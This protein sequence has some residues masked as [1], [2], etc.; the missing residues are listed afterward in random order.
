MLVA[1]STLCLFAASAKAEEASDHYFWRP[2]SNDRISRPWAV[3][4]PGS[5]GL[6]VLGDDQHYF[7]AA[8][9][10]N[11]RGIDALIIDYHGA[12]RLVPDAKGPP[13]ERMAAIVADALRSVRAAGRAPRNCPAAVIAW[14]L[15][16]EGAWTLAA[17]EDSGFRAAAVY[18]PTV[19][20]PRPYGNA[21]P[22]LV[23]QGTAD[24]VTTEA[25]LRSFL[26][27]RP[28]GSATT[29]VVT[30]EGAAHGFDVPSLV[31]ARNMRFPPLIG[32]RVT[33]GY[34]AGSAAGANAALER[35]LREQ[36]VIGG[37][38]ASE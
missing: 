31:P 25:D 16:A 23:L 17:A 35:F 27:G 22:V 6:S 11:Q 5:G 37:V 36:G 10:L 19:R 24:N 3:L 32:Q 26:N 33:F 34:D 7:R 15:G 13:G 2:A 30:F 8:I 18:Y 1:L 4:L 21:L 9:W 28:A 14:S 29:D 38:C 20:R 12:A